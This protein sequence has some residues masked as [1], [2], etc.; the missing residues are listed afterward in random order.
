MASI[1][2]PIIDSID[3]TDILV[4]IGLV[5]SSLVLVFVGL[6]FV[7]RILP[8]MILGEDDYER[9][10]EHRFSKRPVQKEYTGALEF[11]NFKS[12][13]KLNKKNDLN[14]TSEKRGDWDIHDFSDA[15]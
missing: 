4:A 13:Q 9:Y 8:Q 6:I 14:F 15:F 3:V 1:L 2:Q 10:R 11:L 12:G 5:G 7:Y